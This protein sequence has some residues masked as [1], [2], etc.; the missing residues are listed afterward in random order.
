MSV[1]RELQL[2]RGCR[3]HLYLGL[4]CGLLVLMAFWGENSF[5]APSRLFKYGKQL[6]VLGLELEVELMRE[7]NAVS[8]SG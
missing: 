2:P 1:G 4:C 3:T 5:V 6:F 7:R 8:V